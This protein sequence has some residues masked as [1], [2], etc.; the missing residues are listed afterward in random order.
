MESSSPVQSSTMNNLINEDLIASGAITRN[1]R[2]KS[3]HIRHTIVSCAIR[4]AAI[5]MIGRSNL[6]SQQ[7]RT[8]LGELYARSMHS[9][10]TSESKYSL[11]VCDDH[12]NCNNRLPPLDSRL[13]FDN[14]T[15]NV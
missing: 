3:L 12:H 4:Y 8:L 11:A 5:N 9:Q 7:V 15:L 10:Q 2:E 1:R 6:P 13:T 14:F